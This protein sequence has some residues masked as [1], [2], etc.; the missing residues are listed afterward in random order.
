MKIKFDLDQLKF[1]EATKKKNSIIV[2]ELLIIGFCNRFL[3]MYTSRTKWNLID[4]LSKFRIFDE[5]EQERS[6]NYP[7]NT[8]HLSTKIDNNPDFVRNIVN[9]HY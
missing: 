2:S 4:W 7:Y 3:E 5:L 6:G 1:I 8:W 9:K